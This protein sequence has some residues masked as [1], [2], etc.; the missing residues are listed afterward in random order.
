MQSP[1]GRGSGAALGVIAV[2]L[3]AVCTFAS[4]YVI[5]RS[6]KSMGRK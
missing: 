1:A 3:V 2:I 4:H 5:E 6:Q